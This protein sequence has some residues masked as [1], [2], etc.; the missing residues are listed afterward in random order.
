MQYTGYEL[1]LGGFSSGFRYYS[2][3]NMT[4][5][6]SIRSPQALGLSLSEVAE[7]YYDTENIEPFLQRLLPIFPASRP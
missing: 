6:R 7:Y 3:D 4:Q 5:I 2:A 1:Q